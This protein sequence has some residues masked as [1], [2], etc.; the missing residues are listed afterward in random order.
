MELWF[1]RCKEDNLYGYFN[2]FLISFG[3]IEVD[4]F[5]DDFLQS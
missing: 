3:E 2:G 1:G 4:G 5:F